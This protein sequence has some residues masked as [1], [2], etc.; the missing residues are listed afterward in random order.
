MILIFTCQNL[1][2]RLGLTDV[3]GAVGERKGAKAQSFIEKLIII[4]LGI[5]LLNTCHALGFWHGMIPTSIVKWG[6]AK[7]PDSVLAKVATSWES[8]R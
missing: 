5:V 2:G 3:A 1:L 4:C 7:Q 6:G 8:P